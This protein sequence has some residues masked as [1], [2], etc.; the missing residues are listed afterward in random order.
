L[1]KD[2]L[3]ST[4]PDFLWRTSVMLLSSSFKINLQYIGV[5]DVHCSIPRIDISDAYPTQ[6]LFYAWKSIPGVVVLDKEMAQFYMKQMT[7]AVQRVEYVAG[8]FSC[9]QKNKTKQNKKSPFN[10]CHHIRI[11]DSK[12]RFSSSRSEYTL[13]CE[14]LSS[15]SRRK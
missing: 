7:T 6:H 3:C 15:R 13:N 8:E 5:L 10:F 4:V 1:L 9:E 11:K 12:I 14:V 2:P